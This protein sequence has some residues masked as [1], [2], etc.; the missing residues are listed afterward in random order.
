MLLPS[1]ARCTQKKS[2]DTAEA[3]LSSCKDKEKKLEWKKKSTNA[4]WETFMKIL[5]GDHIHIMYT[6]LIPAFHLNF[7]KEM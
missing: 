3:F 5:E 7:L 1:A 6:I 4:L 2:A